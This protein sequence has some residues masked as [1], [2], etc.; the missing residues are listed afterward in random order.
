MA[1]GIVPDLALMI[2]H[3]QSAIFCIVGFPLGQ[4]LYVGITR[5]CKGGPS[6]THQVGQSQ[7]IVR[8]LWQFVRRMVECIK[9]ELQFMTMDRTMV[10][11]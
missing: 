10:D 4:S 8:G 3:H 5:M 11:W 1:V 9:T 2:E 6:T 7:I